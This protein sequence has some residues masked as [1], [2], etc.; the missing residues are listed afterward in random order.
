MRAT[1]NIPEQMPLTE[2]QDLV[3][4][5]YTEEAQKQRITETVRFVFTHCSTVYAQKRTTFSGVWEY[6]DLDKKH[7]KTFKRELKKVL[8]SSTFKNLKI[9]YGKENFDIVIEW[10]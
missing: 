7:V 5:H 4:E 1:K 6:V 2:W 8:T 3:K 9:A 10:E